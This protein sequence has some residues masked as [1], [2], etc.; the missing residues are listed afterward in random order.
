MDVYTPDEFLAEIQDIID[1]YDGDP[2]CEHCACDV[3]MF[4]LLKCLGYTEAAA[5][6]KSRSW[7]YA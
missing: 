3:E 4:E 7:W 2:E 1:K 5:L 6:L